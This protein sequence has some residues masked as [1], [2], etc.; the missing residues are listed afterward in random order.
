MSRVRYFPDPAPEARAQLD[1]TLER[2]AGAA[3]SLPGFQLLLLGGGY[4][5]GEGG[6]WQPDPATSPQLYNDL[7]FYIF[8]DRPTPA[9]HDWVRSEM[10]TGHAETGIE[11]EFKILRDTTLRKARPSMF[12]YDLLAGHLVIAGDDS[13]LSTL[14]ARLSDPAALPADEATRLLMNRGCSLLLCAQAAA[15]AFDLE[16]GFI[17]RIA[18]KLHLALGD[19]LLCTEGR[20]HWSCRERE[21]RLIELPTDIPHGD[22]LRAWH[23][24]GVQFKLHPTLNP[25][26]APEWL[27]AITE[28]RRVWRDVFL[29]IESSRL[30]HQFATPADYAAFPGPLLPHEPAASNALRHL[31]SLKT[32]HRRLPDRWTRHPREAVLRALALL[33]DPDRTT[34]CVEKAAAIL[35]CPPITDTPGVEAAC[36]Q[37]WQQ[38]P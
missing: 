33:I 30:V 14:P 2:M 31:R 29:W 12:Y 25:Q 3:R 18:A 28:L 13:W 6:L 21:A 10:E 7:E 19:A 5:R 35:G 27:P 32:L 34:S 15:G 17:N 23:R 36:R 9:H 26:P 4:G 11:I 24:D 22:Q 1:R 8:V 37:W 38:F 16:P 20:Y